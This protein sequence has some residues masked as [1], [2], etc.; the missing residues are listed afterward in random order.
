MKEKWSPKLQTNALENLAVGIKNSSH[1]LQR[2]KNSMMSS[3][4]QKA[5]K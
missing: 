1:S 2:P 5:S 3:I 4:S